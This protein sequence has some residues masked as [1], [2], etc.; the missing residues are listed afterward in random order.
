MQVKVL[1]PLGMSHSTF[2]FKKAM[3]GDYA[4][5]HDV[6]IDGHLAPSGET[7]LNYTDHLAASIRPAAFGPALTRSQSIRHDGTR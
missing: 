7:T 2:D 5:P 4:R 1:N 6:D 3:Q